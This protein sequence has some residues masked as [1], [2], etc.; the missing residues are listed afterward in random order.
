MN[1]EA[2]WG[3][4]P[5]VELLAEQ[6]EAH[7]FAQ[8]DAAACVAQLG[9]VTG[10]AARAALFGD[11]GA[12]NFLSGDIDGAMGAWRRAMSSGQPM[13]TAQAMVNLGLTYESLGLHERA[14]SIFDAAIEHGIEPH[15]TTASVA[16]ARSFADAGEVETASERLTLLTDALRRRRPGSSQLTGA[17]YGLGVTALAAHQVGD[18]ERAW[19]QAS[20]RGSIPAWRSLIS[21][22]EGLGRFDE[23]D[24]LIAA[25]SQSVD[26][27]SAE[28]RLSHA[29]TLA[30]IDRTD[31]VIEILATIDGDELAP[32]DRFVFAGELNRHGLVNESIGELEVLLRDPSPEH[33]LRAATLLGDVYLEHGMADQAVDMLQEVAGANDPYWSPP[34]A[35]TLGDTHD[36]NGDAEQA[37]GY[38]VQ[39][40]SSPMVTVRDAASDRLKRRVSVQSADT[41]RIHSDQNQEQPERVL[42]SDVVSEQTAL[43]PSDAASGEVDTPDLSDAETDDVEVEEP[44]GEPI[45]PAEPRVISLREAAARR[46]AA[47]RV[48]PQIVDLRL[49][50]LAPASAPAA[51]VDRVDIEPE[52]VLVDVADPA[53]RLVVPTEPAPTSTK[54]EVDEPAR[55]SKKQS[56]RAARVDSE[57]PFTSLT[58]PPV[59]MGSAKAG[60]ARSAQFD[61][62]TR[63][64]RNDRSERFA[65][66]EAV[67]PYADLAP[68]DLPIEAIYRPSKNPYAELAPRH[69]ESEW[70][71]WD[72]SPDPADWTDLAR[73]FDTSP[74]PTGESDQAVDGESGAG[75]RASEKASRTRKSAGFFSSETSA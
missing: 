52:P 3:P 59:P 31:D 38:W 13:P 69:T 28:D 25:M 2:D 44:K 1:Q 45:V 36:E 73:L 63:S 8:P 54:A 27:L 15:A 53:P 41:A 16:A 5:L 66:P 72:I 33:H 58:A 42:E 56:T 47:T 64:E 70:A 6:L 11:L 17:L 48:A 20:E 26:G 10:D 19:R 50:R 43:S 57:S 68:A 18:A 14:R 9:E 34:A 75:S 40:A 51:V 4:A 49:D 55:S 67:D 24:E 35:L 37:V 74:P 60:M 7:G 32:L 46:P 39:A 12:C 61:S 65:P 21:L 29:R 71:E 62:S 22:M 23:V 30:R